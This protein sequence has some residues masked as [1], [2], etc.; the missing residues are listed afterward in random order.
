MQMPKVPKTSQDSWTAWKER[1]LTDEQFAAIALMH[2]S[3]PEDQAIEYVGRFGFQKAC[4][5]DMEASVGFTD[6]GL[7]HPRS[8]VRSIV[9]DELLIYKK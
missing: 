9:K 2:W 4:D 3:V 1:S 8:W 5:V 7:H 6:G